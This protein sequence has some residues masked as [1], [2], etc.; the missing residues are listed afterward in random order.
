[1]KK[2]DK[3]LESKSKTLAELKASVMSLKTDIA[4][5]SIEKR[6]GR[7]QNTMLP[8]HKRKQLAQVLTEIR[9]KEEK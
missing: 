4:K 8:S 3:I 6:T 1:M 2:T 9:Q 5:L 7:L